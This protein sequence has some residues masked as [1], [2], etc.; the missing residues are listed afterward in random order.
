MSTQQLQQLIAGLG[1]SGVRNL[2]ISDTNHSVED[3]A[4]ALND[5]HTINAMRA[6]GFTNA[7]LE[8][9]VSLNSDPRTQGTKQQFAQHGVNLYYPDARFDAYRASIASISEDL[10]LLYDHNINNFLFAAQD[11]RGQTLSASQLSGYFPATTLSETQI[12]QMNRAIPLLWQNII[13]PTLNAQTT[14]NI[15]NRFPDNAGGRIFFYGA[16]HINGI[17]DD[18][19]PRTAPQSF[20][21][22]GDADMDTAFPGYNIAILRDRS[23]RPLGVNWTDRPDFIYYLNEPV[24]RQIEDLRARQE[25]SW[26]ELLGR[27]NRTLTAGPGVTPA[28]N[29]LPI[30]ELEPQN[31]PDA[32]ETETHPGTNNTMRNMPWGNLIGGALGAWLTSSMGGNNIFFKVIAM[33]VGTLIGWVTGGAIGGNHGHPFS[34][35]FNQRDD[36]PEQSLSAA[37]MPDPTRS[38]AFANVTSV[39]ATLEASEADRGELLDAPANFHVA[40]IVESS[41]HT[42]H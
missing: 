29:I 34:G 37:L 9:P 19:D 14:A 20:N 8:G 36:A 27:G 32:P 3:D 38:L 21:F 40:P 16:T 18:Q 42:L 2:H 11:S 13:D 35:V 1:A 17:Y 12:E 4:N 6:G 5:V 10:A 41:T 7:I 28:R 25:P 30:P 23:E 31:T 33:A 24:E 22:T 39:S 26:R 15:R